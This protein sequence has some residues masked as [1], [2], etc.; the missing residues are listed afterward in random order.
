[1]AADWEKEPCP[2]KF[3]N[4]VS[5][6]A[7]YCHN[8]KDSMPRKCPVWR[9]CGE[10]KKTSWLPESPHMQPYYGDKDSRNVYVTRPE[11]PESGCPEF[12]PNPDYVKPT[13]DN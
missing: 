12:E 7:C 13:T 3:G 8:E 10:W 11:W 2:C 4:I 1:M 9:N 6:H 5:G